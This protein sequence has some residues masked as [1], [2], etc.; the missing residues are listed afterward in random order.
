MT[1][2][3]ERRNQMVNTALARIPAPLKVGLPLAAAAVVAA[4][5]SSGGSGSSGAAAAGGAGGNGGATSVAMVTATPGTH[6]AFLTDGMGRAVYMWDA[7]PNNMSSCNGA[8]ANQ[9]PPLTT[10]AAPKAGTGGV[11]AN[12]LGTITRSDGTKQVTYNGHALYTYVGDSRP[13]QTTGQGSDAFGAKWWLVAPSGKVITTPDSEKSAPAAP[14]APASTPST[15]SG[16]GAGGAW[17]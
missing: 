16:G 7:D 3:R 1:P 10:T 6:S 17:G 13:D 14:S 4:A 12:D 2:R 15:N 8:C 9:W 11:Q 5:C